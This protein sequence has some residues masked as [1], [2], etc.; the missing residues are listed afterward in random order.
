MAERGTE[1]IYIYEED[2][3][4]VENMILMY[5]FPRLL[6]VRKKKLK[7]VAKAERGSGA[8]KPECGVAQS[9]IFLSH[10]LANLG[11]GLLHAGMSDVSEV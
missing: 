5:G 3:Q 11:T 6:R 7:T 4:E 1:D 8:I 10:P 2:V 9:T